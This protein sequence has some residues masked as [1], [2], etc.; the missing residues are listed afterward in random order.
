MQNDLH[1][2][3]KSAIP[4]ENAQR[5]LSLSELL[6]NYLRERQRQERE[7]KKDREIAAVKDKG[8]N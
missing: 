3:E 6:N 2:V 4:D 1:D 7:A 5:T 8:T